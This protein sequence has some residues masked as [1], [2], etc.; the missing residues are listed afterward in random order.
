MRLKIFC[1]PYCVRG[2][3]FATLG[4]MNI[5]IGKNHQVEYKIILKDNKPYMKKTTRAKGVYV[6]EVVPK[7]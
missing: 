7:R 1:C 5:H 3:R 6:T 4:A 2:K